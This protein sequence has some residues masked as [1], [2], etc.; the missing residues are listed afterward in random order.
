M[1]QY[2]TVLVDGN[3]MRYGSTHVERGVSYVFTIDI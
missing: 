1:I 2:N 3:G